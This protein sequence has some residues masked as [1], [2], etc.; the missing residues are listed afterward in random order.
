[1]SSAA[2]AR[3]IRPASSREYPHRGRSSVARPSNQ[4]KSQPSTGTDSPSAISCSK[5]GSTVTLA[6]SQPTP[7]AARSLRGSP[8]RAPA[9]RAEPGEQV[10]LGD[11]APGRIAGPDEALPAE[12]LLG[13]V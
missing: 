5:V 7:A 2:A 3:A 11:S 13:Y 6:G 10:V 12:G 9:R 1:M 4:E 8:G